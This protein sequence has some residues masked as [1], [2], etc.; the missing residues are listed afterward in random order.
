MTALDLNRR[1]A[2]LLGWTSI[3]QLGGA[4]LGTPPAGEPNCR[5]QAKVPDWVDDWRDCGPLI[6]A[7]K[8][9]LAS[10]TIDAIAGCESYGIGSVALVD[11]E[12]DDTALRKAI[13]LAVIAKL[14]A[15]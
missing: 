10:T 8:M 2:T 1:L 6:A 3:I 12:S 14:E 7:H 9:R 13:V 4:L 11:Q 5:N 15:Q